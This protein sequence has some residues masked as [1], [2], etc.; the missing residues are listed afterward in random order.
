M[1]LIM[2]AA[3]SVVILHPKIISDTGS[4]TLG[5]PQSDSGI[6]VTVTQGNLASGKNGSVTVKAGN[7]P[8]FYHYSIPGTDSS[9][10]TQNEGGWIVVGNPSGKFDEGW[11]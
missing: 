9:G 7:T 3:D 11:R 8:G 10:V 6:T 4:V 1:I 2:T 5:S